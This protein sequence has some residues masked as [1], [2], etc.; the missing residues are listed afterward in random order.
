MKCSKQDVIVL[1]VLCNLVVL[2]LLL[3]SSNQIGKAGVEEVYGFDAPKVQRKALERQA[4][5]D[6]VSEMTSVSFDEIDQLLEDYIPEMEEPQ[7]E[8][9]PAKKETPLRINAKKKAKQRQYYTVQ[10]GDNPWKIA[11]KF[12]I[13]Y[14]KLL[15]L[16][17]LDQARAKN[18]QIG[19]KLLIEEAT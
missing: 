3:A 4:Q 12:H 16:N 19:Q 8:V 17:K 14:D 15:E 2:A 13:S 6:S 7:E 11:K 1:T 5:G 9:R 18:L 10:S